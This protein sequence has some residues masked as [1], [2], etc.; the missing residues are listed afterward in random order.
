[1]SSLR[2]HCI[3]I[4]RHLNLTNSNWKIT[5]LFLCRWLS[6]LEYVSYSMNQIWTVLTILY[7]HSANF[8]FSFNG[9]QR[10][11]VFCSWSSA[12]QG[13]LP[14]NMDYPPLRLIIY[15]PP[16]IVINLLFTRQWLEFITTSNIIEQHRQFSSTFY[17]RGI[18]KHIKQSF[19]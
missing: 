13:T 11:S 5:L 19:R 8:C 16:P 6:F 17:Y 2:R 14:G 12:S 18:F 9:I 10:Y 3:S 15:N 1:L 7:W 4:S